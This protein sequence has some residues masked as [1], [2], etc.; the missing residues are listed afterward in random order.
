MKG[1]AADRKMELQFEGINVPNTRSVRL[2]PCGCEI[3]PRGV[4]KDIGEGVQ[5]VASGIARW[6]IGL[7]PK[8]WSRKSP[9]STFRAK[10]LLR[11]A[12]RHHP[13]ECNGA[14]RLRTAT[15]LLI[16]SFRGRVPQRSRRLRTALQKH[17]LQAADNMKK[18][19]KIDEKSNDDDAVNTLGWNT[20]VIAKCKKEKVNNTF[21][22][23]RRV[24]PSLHTPHYPTV[25]LFF[26]TGSCGPAD[27]VAVYRHRW[28]TWPGHSSEV[29]AT[30]KLQALDLN[31]RYE[32]RIALIR[33]NLRSQKLGSTG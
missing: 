12:A 14:K 5:G 2:Y 27:V 16:T 17:Q 13:Y 1:A 32:T 23:S 28:K 11:I 30:F 29:Q 20:E 9:G 33:K 6:L 21:R 25:Q 19:S 7:K 15:F 26:P 18:K 31:L 4:C 8:F 22:I 24:P 10:I 3:S